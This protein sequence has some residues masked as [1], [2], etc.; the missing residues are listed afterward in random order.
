MVLFPYKAQIKLTKVPMVTVSAFI[1]VLFSASVKAE[2][3]IGSVY[4]LMPAAYTQE[5]DS[6]W[7]VV[8]I[9]PIPPLKHDRALIFLLCLIDDKPDPEV[10][11]VVDHKPGL[12]TLTVIHDA[13]RANRRTQR[14]EK[15]DPRGISC[16]NES[17]GL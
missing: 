4:P 14:F 16:I 12:Q 17:Y 2:A 13:W 5:D 8:A 15:V 7:R 10:V 1:A 6:K 11:A 3:V 9:L